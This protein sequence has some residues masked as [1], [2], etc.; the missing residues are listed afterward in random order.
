[1]GSSGAIA[2]LTGGN[3]RELAS[4]LITGRS[5]LPSEL[6]PAATR[7]EIMAC[8]K[9]ILDS[10]IAKPIEGAP[11]IPPKATVGDLA[12]FATRQTA[13]LDKANA[14]IEALVEGIKLCTPP[15]QAA[16]R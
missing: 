9:P 12:V 6:D 3:P 15:Q 13:Q 16:S 14:R 8:L 4:G 11:L 10:E 5:V 1:M 2:S 7:R